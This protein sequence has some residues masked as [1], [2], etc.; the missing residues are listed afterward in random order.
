MTD[1]VDDFEKH[2]AEFS[3]RREGAEPEAKPAEPE[4]PTVAAEP[5]AQPVPAAEPEVKEPAPAADDEVTRLKAELDA[6]Q[7][8]LRR[9]TGSISG[10]E[11]H[12]QAERAERQDERAERIKLQEAIAQLTSKPNNT[13]EAQEADDEAIAYLKE[14][15][16]D[17]SGALEKMVK[18]EI[19]GLDQRFAQVDTR[20][21]EVVAP[22]Q[23]HVVSEQTAREEAALARV[24]PNWRSVVSSS[25]YNDWL[26]NQPAAVQSLMDSPIASDAVWL[27]NQY[28]ASKAGTART[29]QPDAKAEVQARRQRELVQSVGI[30]SRSTPAATGT[31]G[32]DDSY[33]GAFE[34]YSRQRELRNANRR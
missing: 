17:L 30:Q 28:Q 33:E 4:T 7:E 18:R 19:K 9:A 10:Y 6:A 27:L 23:Q 5:Q 1:Q 29:P 34:Y 2:F 22:I 3:A 15:F 14:N 20:I 13:P 8:K 21:S 32:I 31:T 12:L 26:N 16:P 11:R 25:E 24:H